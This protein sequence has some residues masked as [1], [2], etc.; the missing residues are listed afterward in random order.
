MVLALIA[1]AGACVFGFI[2]SLVFNWASGKSALWNMCLGAVL[3][4]AGA[5]AGSLG[6]VLL[7][8]RMSN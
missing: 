2:V 4:L 5:V 1:V 8:R 7:I 3:F 6:I